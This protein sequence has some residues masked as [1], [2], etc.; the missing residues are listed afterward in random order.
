MPVPRN[1]IS[2]EKNVT[3]TREQRQNVAYMKTFMSRRKSRGRSIEY[4][5]IV[6][7]SDA[8]K[9][10]AIPSSLNIPEFLDSVDKSLKSRSASEECYMSSR[11]V[12]RFVNLS[13]SNFFVRAATGNIER[14]RGGPLGKR[15]PGGTHYTAKHGHRG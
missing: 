5:Q 15:H 6:L 9:V 11:R 4:F 10:C 7:I 3:K 1:P 2:S 8:S 14:Q 13:V 12:V